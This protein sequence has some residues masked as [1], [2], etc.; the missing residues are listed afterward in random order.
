ML[1]LGA[2]SSEVKTARKHAESQEMSEG[3]FHSGTQG[4]SP[5]TP[6]PQT[7]YGAGWDEDAEWYEEDH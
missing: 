5:N 7:Q 2:N 3:D 6:Y 1:I 4:Y